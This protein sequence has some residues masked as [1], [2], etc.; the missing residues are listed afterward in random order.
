M[1]RKEK[2]VK[3]A[4]RFTMLTKAQLVAMTIPALR[5][6]LRRVEGY[7]GALTGSRAM[8]NHPEQLR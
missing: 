1:T 5:L 6:F 4:L 2:I 7:R 3:R 8:G